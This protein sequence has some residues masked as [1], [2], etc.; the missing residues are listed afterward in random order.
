MGSAYSKENWADGILRAQP[1][2][3][4]P[5]CWL[6]IEGGFMEKAR[7]DCNCHKTE[8]RRCNPG[9]PPFP[10]SMAEWTG[11]PRLPQRPLLDQEANWVNPFHH[12][13]N[14]YP[15]IEEKETKPRDYPMIEPQRLKPRNI[16]E[17]MSEGD[18]RDGIEV[19]IRPSLA[20]RGVPEATDPSLDSPWAQVPFNGLAPP[21]Q[22]LMPDEMGHQSFIRTTHY[23]RLLEQLLFNGED[24]QHAIWHTNKHMKFRPE[25]TLYRLYS[26]NRTYVADWDPRVAI[27][28]LAGSIIYQINV[29][30]HEPT[31]DTIFKVMPAR[32]THAMQHS[33]IRAVE[34]FSRSVPKLLGELKEEVDQTELERRA[35]F[36]APWIIYVMEMYTLWKDVTGLD[37][38]RK[39]PQE[40]PSKRQVYDNELLGGPGNPDHSNKGGLQWSAN[41]DQL[42][43]HWE[44]K[45]TSP[46]SDETL[47]NKED[48]PGFAVPWEESPY[49]GKV[50]QA[51]D[52]ANHPQYEPWEELTYSG[53]HRV[54]KKVPWDEISEEV[55]E[56]AIR[57]RSIKKRE[58]GFV[59]NIQD[60]HQAM[61]ILNP[62][63]RE[64]GHGQR[65]NRMERLL[66]WKHRDTAEDWMVKEAHK[67]Y[68][69]IG[70]E[71]LCM[72]MGHAI[73]MII[74]GIRQQI[75]PVYWRK[76]WKSSP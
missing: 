4:P 71:N 34:K 46:E 55:N 43:E 21:T 29:P 3:M 1:A 12:V 53:T 72:E 24:V 8:P 13:K 31:L 36:M 75:A 14:P 44:G 20:P 11:M 6:F 41:A 9:P 76:T 52:K 27:N 17:F 60:V 23:N 67:M 40:Q 48:K 37:Y 49:H 26:D 64:L 42:S 15:I 28:L 50:S 32:H 68:D 62:K 45:K 19:A 47:N 70:D 56:A 73:N 63:L 16:T 5:G 57:W 39:H 30:Q 25:L 66:A 58:K 10:D 59:T 18:H 69:W 61:D 51:K 7:I 35:T 2:G 22:A 38:V 54:P 33:V 65:L 74:L